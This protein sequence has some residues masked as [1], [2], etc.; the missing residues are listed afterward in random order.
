M[1][2]LDSMLGGP[3]DAMRRRRR[4]S[5]LDRFNRIVSPRYEVKDT[6]TELTIAVDVPGVK[7]EDIQ[8]SLEDDGKVLSIQGQRQREETHG[9]T[10][11]STY[12]SSRFSQSFTLDPTVDP[13]KFTAT[14][15]N[16]VLVVTAPKDLQRL[17]QNIRRIPVTPGPIDKNE[18]RLEETDVV[19]PV[20]P[21]GEDQSTL[22]LDDV[23]DS[24]PAANE[25]V[26]P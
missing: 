10:S 23:P 11:S 24:P 22:D 2:L 12:S 16:G 7:L 14:L 3:H 15:E 5:A 1:L 4:E 26:E 20:A 17:E 25:P 6:E 18:V 19:D 9:E 21:T 8:V 13:E